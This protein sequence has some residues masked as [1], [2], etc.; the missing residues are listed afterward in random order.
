MK[1]I[2]SILAQGW[3][4]VVVTAVLGSVAYGVATDSFI[5]VVVGL[6]LAIVATVASITY[7]AWEAD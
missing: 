3:L 6:F 5:R 2:I 7:L 1:N 4:S